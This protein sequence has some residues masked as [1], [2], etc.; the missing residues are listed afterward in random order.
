ML[1]NFKHFKGLKSHVVDNDAYII[2]KVINMKDECNVGTNVEYIT[3]LQSNNYQIYDYK[4]KQCPHCN[5]E[6]LA[7]PK[8]NRR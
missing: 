5:K 6:N 7:I 3:N 4:Y 1:T 2:H 8:E